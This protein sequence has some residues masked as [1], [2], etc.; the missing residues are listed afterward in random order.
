[1]RGPPR[2]NQSSFSA[3]T[4]T[5]SCGAQ[6]AFT[7]AASFAPPVMTMACGWRANTCSR[8]ICGQGVRLSAKTFC[9][10]HSA[11]TALQCG[12][13]AG[14]QRLGAELQ[15]HAPRWVSGILLFESGELAAKAFRRLM[16][17][18][19]VRA[20]LRQLVQQTGDPFEGV[21]VRIEDRDAERGELIQHALRI[22]A[23]P[24]GSD[25]A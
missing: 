20:V 8:L 22:A 3:I 10:P 7:L 23:A 17:L 11:S 4:G 2:L 12:A 6:K 25:P 15:Q 9:P 13:G 1:M 19:R 24:G 16:R 5:C 21:G 18:L 14:E